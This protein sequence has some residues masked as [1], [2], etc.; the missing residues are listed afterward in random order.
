MWICNLTVIFEQYVVIC[1]EH[2]H[3]QLENTS[4][5]ALIQS[6]HKLYNNYRT[7]YDSTLTVSVCIPIPSLHILH[8]IGHICFVAIFHLKNGCYLM[9]VFDIPNHLQCHCK[10]LNRAFCVCVPFHIHSEHSTGMASSERKK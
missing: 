9:C 6:V 10:R 5:N 8:H 2:N 4:T 3:N 7:C 1:I